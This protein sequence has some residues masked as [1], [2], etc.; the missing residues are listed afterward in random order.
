MQHAQ[1]HNK[2]FY[3]I[4]LCWLVYTCSYIGKLSYNANI[5]QIGL[6]FG[7]P[8]A[9]TGSVSTFF[10]FAYGAGQIING[11]CCKK[12]NIRGVIFG[13]LLVASAMNILIAVIPTFSLLKY[14]W[15]ING[16]AMSFLW[17]SLILLLSETLHKQDVNK[18][19]VD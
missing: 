5:N 16:A 8:Y 11:F 15:L 13:S 17:T 2:S 12:Y 4:A 10:F 3:L 6:A 9:Q 18:A 19:I 14:V 7:V 1:K